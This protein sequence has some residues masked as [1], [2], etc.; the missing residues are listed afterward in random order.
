MSI[1]ADAILPAGIRPNGISKLAHSEA[2]TMFEK[3]FADFNRY[4][5]THPA[6]LAKLKLLFWL[7]YWLLTGLMAF[8]VYLL[9]RER[10]LAG[11]PGGRGSEPRK[12][13]YC[14]KA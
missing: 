2:L 11:R 13:R 3:F 14:L 1:V 6:F 7:K 5:L 8:F 9:F 4:L 10:G 12:K